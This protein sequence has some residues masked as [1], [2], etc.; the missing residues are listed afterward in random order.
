M[1][2]TNQPAGTVHI[3][4]VKASIWRRRE[5]SRPDYTVAFIRQTTDES[6][7]VHVAASFRSEDLASLAR[8]AERAEAVIHDLQADDLHGTSTSE[9]ATRLRDGSR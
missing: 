1:T 5:G 4:T 9:E 3:G 6:G 2:S 7:Q 8:A